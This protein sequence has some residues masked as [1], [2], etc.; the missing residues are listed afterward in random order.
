MEEVATSMGERVYV[1]LTFQ[2][3]QRK[4]FKELSTEL[5]EKWTNIGEH[6]SST[7]FATVLELR[8]SLINKK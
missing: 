5:Q 4:E 2:L 3:P 6:V 1:A 8:N 7:M